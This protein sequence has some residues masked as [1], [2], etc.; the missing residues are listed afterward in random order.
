MHYAASI[1]EK[2]KAYRKA[3]RQR[4]KALHDRTLRLEKAKKLQDDASKNLDEALNEGFV[5]AK[6]ADA[7]LR[8]EAIEGEGWTIPLTKDVE[9][10]F[11]IGGTI[12]YGSPQYLSTEGSTARPHERNAQT[13]RVNSKTIFLTITSPEKRITIEK[14]LGAPEHHAEEEAAAHRFVDAVYNATKR[15]DELPGEK[16]S[17]LNELKSA[18]AAA[19][20]EVEQAQA[21]LDAAQNDTYDIDTK[22]SE[23]EALRKEAQSVGLDSS[24]RT[25]IQRWLHRIKNFVVFFAIAF[26]VCCMFQTIV[27]S[28]QP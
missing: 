12:A 13:G 24:G 7:I 19:E 16:E 27:L 17:R 4:R 26:F 25:M 10:S 9:A 5:L 28:M 15:I 11:S 21:A 14:K 18:L 1:K 8:Y 23:L 2:E 3:K 20:K 6:F 22:F